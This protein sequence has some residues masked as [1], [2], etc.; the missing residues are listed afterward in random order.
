MIG[1]T[2]DSNCHDFR[3]DEAIGPHKGWYSAERVQLQVVGAN[4]G[5]S[6]VDEL[7]IQFVLLREGLDFALIRADHS[8]TGRST[9]E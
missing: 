3:E 5:R 1:L 9:H 6:G 8:N 4:I 2:V 7:D